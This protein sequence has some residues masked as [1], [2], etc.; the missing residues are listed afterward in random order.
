[1]T[2]MIDHALQLSCARVEAACASARWPVRALVVDGAILIPG[3]APLRV[4][5]YLFDDLVAHAL[6]RATVERRGQ[7]TW[8]R[9]G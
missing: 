9:V 5:L 3:L 4:G 7:E 6:G 2:G 8:V 1:M